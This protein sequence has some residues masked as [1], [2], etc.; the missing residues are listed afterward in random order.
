MDWKAYCDWTHETAMRRSERGTDDREKS[1][2]LEIWSLGVGGEFLE[3]V[4]EVEDW[5]D[6][7]RGHRRQTGSHPV[8]AEAGDCVYYLARLYVDCGCER[9][10][11]VWTFGNDLGSMARHVGRVVECVKKALRKE[12]R[13]G[14]LRLAISDREEVVRGMDAGEPVYDGTVGRR[15]EFN[16]ILDLALGSIESWLVAHGSTLAEVCEI[17]RKKL[18]RRRAEGTI[19]TQ[20]ERYSDMLRPA[21]GS[22][23]GAF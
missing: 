17:N 2:L 22:E 9:R 18:E 8:L 4:A 15:E 21:R 14:L 23:G 19:S 3:F 16:G 20:G 1:E 11:T 13:L 10:S 12:G 7:L 6:P 5:A